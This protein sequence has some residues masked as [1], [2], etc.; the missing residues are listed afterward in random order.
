MHTKL[1]VCSFTRSRDI[2]ITVFGGVANPES[3]GGEAVGGQGWY[4]SKECWLVP[5]GPPQ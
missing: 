4:R 1:E 2:A 3:R 5:I